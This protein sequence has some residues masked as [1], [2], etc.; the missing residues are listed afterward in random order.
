MKTLADLTKFGIVIFVWLCA[1]AGY[2]LGFSVEQEFSVLHLLKLLIGIGILSAGS[3]ALNQF[4]ESDLDARM[5]RTMGRPIPSG[6]VSPWLALS[7][8]VT[9]LALGSWLLFE[10]KPLVGSLGLLTVFLYNVLYTIVWKRNMPMAAVPGAIPGAMPVVI[11]FAATNSNIFAPECVYAYLIMFFWQM[12]H[13]WAIALKFA[14]DYKQGG[15]PV[16]PVSRGTNRTLFQMGLYTIAYVALALMS[17]WFVE[18]R[19][20]Y[21]LIVIPFAL[22]TL[23]EFRKYFL[24][25][26]SKGWLSFFLWTNFSML[27]F[28]IAPVVDKWFV[29]ITHIQS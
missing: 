26:A 10:V 5:P 3:F 22:K 6:K 9:F 24:S 19:Y 4:Q 12:P 13:Y 14:D 28:L 21:L 27:V 16:L 2:G 29:V 1:L 20:F 17:P 25:G 18:A 7:I 11:G 15:V 8:A 23:W